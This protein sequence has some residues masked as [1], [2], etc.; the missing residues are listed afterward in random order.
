MYKIIEKIFQIY[1][2]MICNIGK[3]QVVINFVLFLIATYSIISPEPSIDHHFGPHGPPTTAV[4]SDPDTKILGRAVT[5][6]SFTAGL[7]H[8]TDRFMTCSDYGI[9]RS[10]QADD[11]SL[12]S[13]F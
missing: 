13:S 6:P 7:V 5:T 8:S 10:K 9:D 1:F 4:W 12:V 3:S 2:N 11:L